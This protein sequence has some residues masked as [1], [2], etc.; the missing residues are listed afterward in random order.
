[1]L[2]SAPGEAR[3]AHT[4]C[5]WKRLRTWR[6][7]RPIPSPPKRCHW[8]RPWMTT[9]PIPAAPARWRS[10]ARPRAGLNGPA[11][12]TGLRSN[13]LPAGITGLTSKGPR[14]ARAHSS[15]RTCAASTGLTGACP[16]T[17]TTMTEETGGTAASILYQPSRGPILLLPAP[18]LRTPVLTGCPCRRLS[19]TTRPL[20]AAPAVGGGRFGHGRGGLCG[21]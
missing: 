12:G 15:I 4:S 13:S 17:R 1:M 18:M 19:M 11:I 9:R 20:P 7:M 10:A 3:Q 6:I 16:G 21:R 14:R 5:W 8:T 2:R